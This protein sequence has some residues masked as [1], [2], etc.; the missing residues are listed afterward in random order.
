MGQGKLTG[1]RQAFFSAIR[2]NI[3]TPPGGKAGRVENPMDGLFTERGTTVEERRELR[4]RFIKEWTTLGGQAFSVKD[5]D[6]LASALTAIIRER[7]IK[8]AV[9]WEH[10]Q[11]ERLNL[12]E[13]FAQA[14]AKLFE[15][16]LAQ[17]YQEWIPV[18]ESM[19]A[20]V[21]W[22]DIAMAETGTLILPGSAGQPTTVSVLP[23]TLIAVFTT[24]Q[25][26]DGFYSAMKLL[27]QRYG[28]NL[29]TTTTFITGPSRTS[30]IE[31]DLTIGVH[32][33][34]YVYVC[35]MDE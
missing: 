8:Q 3:K 18:A 19:E 16:P 33:S 29:P 11:L 13:I 22:G 9:R 6:E 2:N 14:E 32:G 4:E 5:R 10:P 24:A 25:L 28:T 27:K 26:V 35:I 30:D 17:N 20:G 7:G 12:S 15:W 23:I 31:M 34:K 1:D 21:V